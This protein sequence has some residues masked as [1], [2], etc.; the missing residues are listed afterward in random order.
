VKKWLIEV[1]FLTMIALFAMISSLVTS[2]RY[3][4]WQWFGRS[5]SIITLCGAVL[6]VRRLIRFGPRQMVINENTIEGGEYDNPK[7]QRR[8]K[9]QERQQFLDHVA[10]TVGLVLLVFGSLIWGYGD[11]LGKLLNYLAITIFL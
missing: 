3:N 7:A 8:Y 6:S 11:L 9:E 2:V 5:G 1:W 4:D 10:A